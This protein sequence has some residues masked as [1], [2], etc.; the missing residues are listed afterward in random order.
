MRHGWVGLLLVLTMLALPNG[1]RADSYGASAAGISGDQVGVGAAED[2]PTQAAADAEAM[3]EC[4]ARTSNCQI[5]GEFSNGGCGFITTAASDGTCYGYGAS[6][7]EA[8]KACESRGCG[9]CQNP[10]GG[11]TKGR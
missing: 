4:R 1:A 10:I 11:C 9:V 7:I 3:K 8:A 6:P 5:V 2:Y